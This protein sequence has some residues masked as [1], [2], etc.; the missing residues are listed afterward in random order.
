MG[1]KELGRAKLGWDFGI[2]EM[3]EVHL[4]VSL[5]AEEARG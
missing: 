5:A 1:G 2:D 3:T 4:W